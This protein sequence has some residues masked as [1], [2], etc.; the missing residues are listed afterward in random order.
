MSG[1]Y[2]GITSTADSQENKMVGSGDMAMAVEGIFGQSGGSLGKFGLSAANSISKVGGY[3]TA[4]DSDIVFN[5]WLCM[6]W[7]T[8][9][10]N[11][12]TCFSE[13][14]IIGIDVPFA[15]A[16]NA[17]IEAETCRGRPIPIEGYL[18]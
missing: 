18:Q 5:R 15:C 17:G 16:A 11:L 10:R 8:H 14:I 3:N 7:A 13:V 2:G 12:R 4:L 9:S 1:S 6:S